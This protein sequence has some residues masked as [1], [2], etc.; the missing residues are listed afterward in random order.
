MARNIRSY[1]LE[2]RTSRLK[3]PVRRKSYTVRI[4]PGIRLCFRR[5]LNAGAW[6][7]LAANGAGGSWLRK[8]GYADD[9]EAA[10]GKSVLDYWQA[11]EAAKKLA[12]TT[13]G[14]SGGERPATVTEAIEAYQRDLAA[15][16]GNEVNA[17]GLI[18]KL[19][20]A[21]ATRPVSLL[22]TKDVIGFRD[23]LVD[24]GIKRATVNRYMTNFLAALRLAARLDRRI[25]NKDDWQI[26]T[27]PSDSV[28]RNIILS[29]G[30][31]R[32]VVAAAYEFDRAFGLL[33]E[34]LAQTGARIGQTRRLTTADLLTGDRLNMPRSRKGRGKAR[35]EKFPVPVTGTLA[36]KLSA[37]AS[38]RPANAPLLLDANGE[39]W[40]TGCQT[41][42]F[43]KAVKA[44]GLDPRH[45]TCYSLRHSHVVAQLLANVP[46]RLVA[47]LHDTSV[48]MI[49]KTYSRYI[50]NVGDEL[51]RRALIDFDTAPTADN[52]VPMVR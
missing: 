27:L 33:C 36:M 48:S 17:T 19:T 30:E 37:A 39:P 21:L 41:V 14:E 5:N 3:L 35:H 12:R 10:D 46:I 49:E 23:R 22:S 16:D 20:P 52:V 8:I 42:P 2:N 4:A 6:S 45:V 32:R 7:V 43:A 13:D 18:G 47:S 31:V 50:S 24:T 25:T 34:V 29:D 9:F 15:R 40:Q 1:S 26:G 51:A 44:V 28:A 11:C 38:G